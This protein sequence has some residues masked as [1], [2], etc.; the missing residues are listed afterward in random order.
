MA[1][2]IEVVLELDNKQY[3]RAIKQSQ[4]N[5]KDFETSSVSSANLVRNAFVALGGAAVVRS[6]ATVGAS[7]QDLQ[8]SLNVVFGSIDDGAAAFGRVQD[9]AAT[10]QF[11][12]QTLTQAFVQLK[13][14]GVEPT[15]ELLQTFAD[16]ASV[17]TDQMG[18]F[19]AALDLVSRSTAG[20]LGL[21]DLNRLADRGI[22]VF[23]I[24][25][26]RLNLTRLQ[27]S[28][29][30]KT[31]EGANTIVRELLA[32][33][34]ERFGGAL[35][36]QVGLLNFELNQLGD[37]FDKLQVS[38]FN[39]FAE[40]AASGVQ[41]LA[42]AINGLADRI[43]ELNDSGGAQTFKDIATNVG[44]VAISFLGLKGTPRLLTTLGDTIMKM[45]G[46]SAVMAVLSNTI[47]GLGPS[48][49]A[50]F[51]NLR[52]AVASFASGS[53]IAG[54]TSVAFSLK[55][56]LGFALRFA[57]LA[58]V[59]IGLAQIIDTL[60]ESFTGFSI[61]DSILDLLKAGAQQFGF[62]KEE[63]KEVADVV[64]EETEDLKI[65]A[66]EA[67]ENARQK[68][69]ARIAEE[70]YEKG[71]RSTTNAIK[72]QTSAF[73]K[74]DPLSEYQEFLK[75]IFE[76]AKRN[77]TEQDNLER[78]LRNVQK[79]L[80]ID[81]NNLYFIEAMRIL[82]EMTGEVKENVEENTEAFDAFNSQVEKIAKN[83]DNYNMMLEKL[84]ELQLLG[85]L[86]AEQFKEAKE[87][88]DQSFTE[89]EGVDNFLKTLGQA[90]KALSEDLAT[91]FLEGQKAGDAFKNFFKKMITQI[92][93]D[94]I[95]LQII[96]PILGAL[97]GPFGYTFGVG[98]SIIPK[99][100]GG[101]VMPGGTYLVGEKG[102]ELLHM[103]GAAGTIT[104]NTQMGGSQVT[105]NINAVDAPS[106]QA[107]VASDPGFIYAVTQA[108]ARTIPGSR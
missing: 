82:K 90:Q 103:G 78:A 18:T 66:K 46:P 39:I 28:E 25:S 40:D 64:E 8:N 44:L 97:L 71:L 12:V 102:P 51:T 93:A 85:K 62:F 104:P 101:P 84:I 4:K 95:R 86:T 80:E 22:P 57:G 15:E 30:G 38:I 16:T 89:N 27:V 9:F 20:G 79:L 68:E 14:A 100:S 2:S 29:F 35:E 98:G 59:F 70:A 5:T 45:R 43:S 13:G 33:L 36:T 77:I 7:F 50:I 99:A 23:N 47:S 92:I 56:A 105:Y 34:N 42:S 21:E 37:A 83:T 61:I 74:N 11:S 75:A 3:N 67:A 81:P 52:R 10:T 41:S 96:Q 94:I 69:L 76:E 26:E 53:I 48:A 49:V 55:A 73:D 17:T 63:I 88:L 91:A 1:R 24:L 6:I 58:G 19:Q 108:G 60:V 65:N 106:F 107:L 72:E 87:N 31:A 54:L 32:G